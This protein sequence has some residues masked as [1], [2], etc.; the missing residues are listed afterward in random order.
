MEGKDYEINNK[1][2][3]NFDTQKFSSTFKINSLLNY[4]NIISD[5]NQVEDIFYKNINCIKDKHII[6]PKNLEVLKD[7][8]LHIVNN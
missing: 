3:F 6:L 2:F 4:S 8:N 7:K 1:R 5:L